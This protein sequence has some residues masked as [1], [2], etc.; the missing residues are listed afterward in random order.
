M[1]SF[2]ELEKE[3]PNGF[4]DAEIRG[5]AIDCLAR[6][7]VLSMNLLFGVGT[8]DDEN[9]SVY[10]PATVR[11]AGLLLFFV[12]PPHPKYNFVLDGEPLSVSGDPVR[13][14]QRP[15]LDCLLPALPQNATVYRFFLNEWN[16]FI[17]LAGTSV[18]FSWDDNGSQ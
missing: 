11:I 8:P 6:T 13:V 10:R 15:E 17:Y 18:E 1:K 9:R 7:V 4:H 2:E 12:Q 3:L 5:I 16:S 14:G